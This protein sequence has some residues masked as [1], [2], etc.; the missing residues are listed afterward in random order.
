MDLILFRYRV[1]DHE[2]NISKDLLGRDDTLWDKLPDEEMA[3]V[4]L[5]NYPAMLNLGAYPWNKIISRNYAENIGFR[6]STT[7]V[8]NDA[9]AHWQSLLFS[10]RI[11]TFRKE[12]VSHM[13][14]SAIVQL[15]NIHD[16]RRLES[17]IFLDEIEKMISLNG[18][19]NY[20]DNFLEFENDIFRWIYQNSL[21]K[22]SIGRAFCSRTARLFREEYDFPLIGKDIIIYGMGWLSIV[23]YN[24]LSCC[25]N[26]V[27]FM[28]SDKNKE[29]SFFF[30]KPIFHPSS[31]N[32]KCNLIIVCSEYEKDIFK[33]LECFGYSNY[34]SI[35]ELL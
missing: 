26:L 21:M 12:V 8:H 31:N 30:G 6:F 4:S 1:E 35:S 27:G 13:F 24:R 29:G 3:E 19:D 25:N 28:D 10:Q 18:F 9:F 15:T 11:I 5:N 33:N 32:V 2:G 23:N 16:K 22:E 14:S 20:L 34:V 7:F 17:L